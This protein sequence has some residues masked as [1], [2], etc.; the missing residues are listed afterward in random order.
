MNL[1]L[2]H[3]KFIFVAFFFLHLAYAQEEISNLPEEYQELIESR[4]SNDLSIESKKIVPTNYLETKKES[5]FEE[6]GIFGLNFFDYTVETNA[7]VLDIPLS[8]DYIV[9]F[10]DELEILLTGNVNKMLEVR[11]D[12]SGNILIPEIGS[13]SVVGLSLA[14]ANTKISVLVKDFYIGTESY[15]SVK[16][17]SLKK[18][19]VI[20]NVKNPGTYLVNPFITL[21]EAIKYASGLNDNS[22]LRSVTIRSDDGQMKNY[23]LYSF[24]MFG[25]REND[26]NLNNGDTVIVNATSDIVFISGQVQREMSY[27]YKSDDRFS[28]L[29]DFALGP[30]IYANLENITINFLDDGVIKTERIDLDDYV[31]DKRI[32]EIFVGEFKSRDSKK[33]FVKGLGAGN[34]FYDFEQNQPLAEVIARLNFSSEFYPFYAVLRQL[35]S[36]GMKNEFYSFSIAD[37]TSYKDIVLKENPE[38]IFFDKETILNLS[39]FFLNKINISVDEELYTSDIRQ[40]ELK[41]AFIGNKAF[42]IPI[43]GRLSPKIFY[44]YFGDISAISVE[45]VAVNL[46]YGSQTGVYETLFDFND[47]I[48]FSFPQI[49]NN[50]FKVTITGQ[51][52]NPGT[53]TITAGTTLDD[54]YKISGGLA[55]NSSVRGIF[56]SRE[57][58]KAAQRKAIESSRQIL[59][60]ALIAQASNPLNSKNADLDFNSILALSENIKF[61]G[62]ISGNFKPNTIESSSFFLEEGDSIYVPYKLSTIT[63]A[64]EVLNPITTTLNSSNT[65]EDYIVFAGGT[66]E[67]ADKDLIYVIKA[68]G[69]AILLNKNFFGKQIYPE[70][71]D[72]IVVPRD[73]DRIDTI[74][75]VSIATKIVSDIAFSAASINALRN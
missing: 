36:S 7:P 31:G 68:N 49:K 44:D 33:L 55:E 23:D 56:F 15:L 51:V 30:K 16:K 37:P 11:V 64:G 14:Q 4:M 2:S 67:F 35:S 27:E 54:L 57:S 46:N 19:S 18:I 66:N 13:T 53:Y 40:S 48:S 69:E 10:N 5:S 26:V 50:T 70:P 61:N 12:M 60:D 34:G 73:L 8:T 45:S 74:P 39:G 21:T 65:Y 63:I 41:L 59:T 38:L 20:G 75:L 22:S 17:P 28:E 3:S 71:G 47:V 9:S 25:E 72:T 42:K 43:K 58:V 1:Y 32:I 6:Q 62:R 29:L 52:K 24:L